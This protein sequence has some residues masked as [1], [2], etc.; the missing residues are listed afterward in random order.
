MIWLTR[1][2]LSKNED[3]ENCVAFEFELDSWFKQ[4]HFLLDKG[5]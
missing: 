4:R 3:R 1:D 2:C 5:K